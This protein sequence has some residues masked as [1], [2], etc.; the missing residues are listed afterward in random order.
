MTVSVLLSYRGSDHYR[1]ANLEKVVRHLLQTFPD[2]EIVFVEQDEESTLS[3]YAVV[4]DVKYVFVSNPGSFNKSWGMNVAYKH[5]TGEILVII[6]GDIIV[7]KD[8]LQRAI[9]A[10]E[11]ELDA[12]R[13]Y[14]Q[15]IDMTLEE[16][17]NYLQ[18]GDLPDAPKKAHGYDRAHADESLCMAGGIFVLR[19]DYFEYVGGMDERFSGWGG[20]D[21]AMSIK[22]QALSSKV[23]IAK[24]AVAWHLWHP[25]QD[26]YRHDGY[27]Q[28]LRLLKQYKSIGKD[29]LLLLCQQDFKS[30]GNA[31]K[32][33]DTKTRQKSTEKI[34]D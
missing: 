15:L 4:D 21:D 17:E 32:F 11:K 19:R 18:S 7:L 22:L 6:D 5:S 2:W 3:A 10:C 20:E 29:D 14:G 8:D 25:R 16:T 23:A 28:N 30:I 33:L 34:N 12:V 27:Q 31:E 26:C 13:P 1:L 24:N 9:N